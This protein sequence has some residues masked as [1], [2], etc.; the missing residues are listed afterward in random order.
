MNFFENFLFENVVSG[1]LRSRSASL[2]NFANEIAGCQYN[3]I[4]ITRILFNFAD[5]IKH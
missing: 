2:F 3:F 5:D 1:N 4:H